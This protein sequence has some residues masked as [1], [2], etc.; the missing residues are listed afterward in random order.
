MRHA[1]RS[2]LKDRTYTAIALLTLAFGIAINTIIFS[3]V[4]GVL[5]KPL[6]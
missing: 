1:I 6:A 5:L 3:I 2:L 4:D